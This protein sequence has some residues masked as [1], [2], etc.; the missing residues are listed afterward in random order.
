MGRNLADE[1]S[2]AIAALLG[3]RGGGSSMAGRREQRTALRPGSP[4][5]APGAGTAMQTARV[6]ASAAAAPAWLPW[7]ALLGGTVIGVGCILG[8]L[9]VAE[10][11]AGAVWPEG[12][13][14][15]WRVD[16]LFAAIIFAPML[17]LALGAA[18]ATRVRA[19]PRGRAPLAMLA[20]GL[21]VGLGGVTVATGYAA[22][23]GV[24]QAG[25]AAVLGPLL[26]LGSAMMLLQSGTEEVL[27]RGWMH[28]GIARRWGAWPAILLTAAVFAGLHVLGGA[29]GIIELANLTL[30]GVLFG[31]L[32]WKSGGLLAPVAAHYGWNWLEG[33]GLGLD[34]NPGIGAYGAVTNVDLVGRALWGG[35][36]VGLNGSLA[37]LMV[38]AALIVP[39]VLWRRGGEPA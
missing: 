2:E 3:P 18:W 16:A 35:S 31:L 12:T 14:A 39:I 11:V 26:L 28:G 17:A 29:R 30:G 27:L 37:M 13:D 1:E 8:G 33:L 32:R 19:L 25:E 34:P 22:F 24:A 6:G 23:A 7:A 20:L 9:A 4:P 38:L 36:P 5:P 10:A 21:A 15:A